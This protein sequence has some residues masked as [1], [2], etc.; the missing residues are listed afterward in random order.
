MIKGINEKNNESDLNQYL[1]KFNNAIGVTYALKAKAKELTLGCSTTLK[2]ANAIF[3][4]VK[5]EIKYKYYENSQKGADKTLSSKLGNCCDQANLIVALCR[6]SG[7]PARYSHG[8]HCY[9]YYSGNYYGHV[10]AQILI[11]NT[12][13][14]ADATSSSNSLGFIRNWNINT[15]N[16]LRQYSLIPF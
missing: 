7:I 2:K 14:A 6:L 8:Q 10:W 15:F 16:T 5:N 11:G 12:W 4:F 3:I 9:F 13:Y 1:K